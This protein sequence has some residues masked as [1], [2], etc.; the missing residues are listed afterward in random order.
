MINKTKG[1]NKERISLQVKRKVMSPFLNT[2]EC[3]WRRRGA[4]LLTPGGGS[5]IDRQVRM[6]QKTGRE[7]ENCLLPFS[8]WETSKEARDVHFPG[9]EDY[10]IRFSSSSPQKAKRWFWFLFFKASV[11]VLS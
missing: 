1:G 7:G 6:C 11:S 2:G 3:E 10:E 4:A 5:L 8:Q 9:E